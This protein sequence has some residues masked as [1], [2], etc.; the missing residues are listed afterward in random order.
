MA[1][2]RC[3]GKTKA[4]KRC[5]SPPLKGTDFCLS[6]SSKAT[7]GK[8]SFGGSENGA[9]GGH[10][11]RVPRLTEILTERVEERADEIM[12]KLF[13]GLDGERALVVGTG[14]N[15]RVEV[16]PDQEMVLKTVREI[17][18]RMEGRPKQATEFKGDMKIRNAEQMQD[19]IAGLLEEL[20]HR[21]NGHAAS[22]N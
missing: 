9:K 16:H 11:K 18:D 12:D 5:K 10:A 21:Q 2:R 8:L 3:K 22:R 13:A 6:H 15:A 14:P 7:R 4:G 1:K 17:W 19:E 20:A